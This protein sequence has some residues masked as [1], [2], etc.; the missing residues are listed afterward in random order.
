MAVR[1]E[2]EPQTSITLIEIPQESLAHL[3]HFIEGLRE[4]QRT[5]ASLVNS[6]DSAIKT[7][8]TKVQLMHG[9]GNIAVL[10]SQYQQIRKCLEDEG[11]VSITRVVYSK[12]VCEVR[13]RTNPRT[14]M[15]LEDVKTLATALSPETPLQVEE[16][17]QHYCTVVLKLVNSDGHTRIS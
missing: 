1:T 4:D 15:T 9:A 14:S 13:I 10:T 12:R 3:D 7:H 16:P 8:Y 11:E 2:Q 5:L 6:A 17:L